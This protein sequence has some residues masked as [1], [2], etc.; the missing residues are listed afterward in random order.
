MTGTKSV[1]AIGSFDEETL[2]SSS[3][4][5]GSTTSLPSA[6]SGGGT[7]LQLATPLPPNASLAGQMALFSR[8]LVD[9][10]RSQSHCRMPFHKFIPSYHHFFGRQCR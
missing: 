10:L 7:H 9:L 6:V 8:E 2:N 3:S 5:S 1:V 4:N